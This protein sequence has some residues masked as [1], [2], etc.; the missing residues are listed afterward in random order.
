MLTGKIL[1]ESIETFTSDLYINKYFYPLLHNTDD[2]L[3]LVNQDFVFVYENIDSKSP[4][5][6]TKVISA[7][8]I[9]RHHFQVVKKISIVM[10]KSHECVV[11]YGINKDGSTQVKV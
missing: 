10:Y 3:C 2:H 1:V 7:K 9:F 4:N 11:L 6:K 8:A 5:D